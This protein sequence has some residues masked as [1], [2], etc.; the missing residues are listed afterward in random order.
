MMRLNAYASQFSDK[1]VSKVNPA[2][3]S[4]A[5]IIADWPLWDGIPGIP[6]RWREQSEEG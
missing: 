1:F 6:T 3:G 2:A 5:G 4:I